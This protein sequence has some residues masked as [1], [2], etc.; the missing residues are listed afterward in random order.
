MV[1]IN[2][3]DTLLA[4]IDAK[5]LNIASFAKVTLDKKFKCVGY[6]CIKKLIEDVT[7]VRLSVS[8]IDTTVKAT[9]GCEKK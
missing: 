5:S 2:E 3:N 1:S 9:R 4:G 6:F 8:E 7:T